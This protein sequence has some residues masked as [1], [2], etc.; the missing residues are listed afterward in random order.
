MVE[1]H[2]QQ[3][4]T[5]AYVD[6][7]TYRRYLD[8]DWDG[9]ISLGKEAIRQGIDFNYLEQRMGYAYYLKSDFYASMKH[10]ER[11]LRFEPKDAN[12]LLYLYYAG[13]ETGNTAYARCR[14]GALSADIK[15]SN[16]LKAI[17]L[18][19]NVDLE[20][21]RAWNQETNRT[22][23]DYLRM[24][25]GSDL[26]YTFSLYQTFSRFNQNADY[27]DTYNQYRSAIRQDEYYVLASKALNATIGV[28]L[29][30]HSVK[31]TFHTDVWDLALQ[32]LSQTYDP[33]TYDGYLWFGDLHAKWHRLHVSVSTSYMDL[34][35][36]TAWQHGI[37]LGWALPGKRKLFI[38]NALYRIK[39]DND[40]WLVSKHSVGMLL[41]PKCWVELSKTFGS[42]NNFVDANGLYVYN[43]FD[44][45]Q[46]KAGLSVY[47][48]ST[49][50]L[51][52]FGNFSME[53]KQ[54][55]YLQ[56]T[57]QQNALTG[58]IAWKF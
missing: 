29:G 48:Y 55:T 30:Y 1:A 9:L 46:S 38:S 21:N 10:Y 2:A 34:S 12:S 45:T 58:G 51:T 27:S 7:I 4:L 36:N 47:W 23:P 13:L 40:A 32:E 42:L 19:S 20:Y 56:H 25:F 22:D 53:T 39:D 24:G 15:E 8:G 43:S 57:Y 17:R 18:V 31:T 26:G 6:S 16:H 5:P 28:D 35:Y 54:N 52:L 14:A 41:L 37:Q 50:H 44:P 3:P 49:A 11:A 33:V